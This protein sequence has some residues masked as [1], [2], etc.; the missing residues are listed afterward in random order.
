M[1]VSQVIQCASATLGYPGT[2]PNTNF[3]RELLFATLIS[4]G[5]GSFD[6]EWAQTV[7][8]PWRSRFTST[9]LILAGE[10]L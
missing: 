2:I 8:D 7:R 10:A 5:E 3:I 4:A 1:I 6:A 9:F